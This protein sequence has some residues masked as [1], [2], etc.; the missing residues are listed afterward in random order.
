MCKMFF[1]AIHVCEYTGAACVYFSV[2]FLS[3]CLSLLPVLGCMCTC[4]IGSVK[5][6]F[7]ESKQTA[8][9]ASQGATQRCEIYMHSEK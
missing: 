2:T 8:C 4:S 7:K 6:T 5:V 1:Y 9:G 3:G